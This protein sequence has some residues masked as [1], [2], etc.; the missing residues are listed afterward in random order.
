MTNTI[1]S[2][3]E[4]NLQQ[5]ASSFQVVHAT[6]GR[7]RLRTND[8]SLK[9]ALKTF[10]KILQ[11]Q[12]GVS[13]VQIHQQTGSLVV[14]FD[15]NKLSQMQMGNWLEQ[16][17]VSQAPAPEEKNTDAF[18]AWKSVDFWKEQGLDFIPLVTGLAVTSGLGISGLAAI[19][20]Y[21]IAA[22]VARGAID[23][24]KDA[25]LEVKGEREEEKKDKEDREKM[26]SSPTHTV[27]PSPVDNSTPYKIVHAVP[28]RIRF[29][30]PWLAQDSV[31]AERVQKLLKAD[32]AIAS[33][34][35]NRDAAS[36]V[37]NYKLCEGISVSHWLDL[38]QAAQKESV[39]Q[40]SP[41][42]V[43][44][45]T[46]QISQPQAAVESLATTANLEPE[47][48]SIS[49]TLLPQP[50]RQIILEAANLWAV[51]KSPALN[52]SLAF[53]ANFPLQTVPE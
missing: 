50:D 28:G 32:G 46:T 31:Y 3:E 52:L 24:T 48:D 2:G 43:A 37:I 9:P 26:P 4:L 17:S 49:V 40:N 36:I 22:G 53:M 23:L 35:M 19:P 1:G 30:V 51:M 42:T 13:E 25:W 44:T 34:R 21:M 14:K 33:F 7:L 41:A 20:V 10:A 15:E 29:N 45:Q 47:S 16:L 27:T 8:R 6:P 39:Q 18:A 11:E 5:I 12:E 38:L